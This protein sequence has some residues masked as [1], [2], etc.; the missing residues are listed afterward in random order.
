ML[1]RLLV[2]LAKVLLVF[3][4]V[5]LAVIGYWQY[6]RR[7]VSSSDLLVYLVMLPLGLLLSY[8]LARGILA[9]GRKVLARRRERAMPSQSAHADPVA[10]SASPGQHAEKP[11]LV[12]GSALCSRLG[13]AETWIEKTREYEIHHVLDR[14]LTDAL[15]WAVRSVRVDQLDDD[16]K[17]GDGLPD[18]MQTGV[19]RMAHMLE[20]VKEELSGVLGQAS[21]QATL[22]NRTSA[23]A[24]PHVVLHPAWTGQDSPH[25][26]P[27]PAP[28]AAELPG[29]STLA[30]V[31]FLPGFVTDAEAGALAASSREWALEAG[32]PQ[33]KVAVTRV[34]APDPSVS[35]RR[36]GEVLQQQ[37][38]KPSQLLVVLSAVSWLDETVLAEQLQRNTAWAERLQ[39]SSTVVGEAA[40][41]MVLSTHPL[42]DPVTRVEAPVLAHLSRLSIGERQKP[43]DVK[44]SVE[45]ELLETLSQ[46]LGKAHGILPDQY[47]QLVATG[48][49]WHGR[50]VELGRWLSDCLPHLSLVDD[51]I[52]VGQ[53][54]G[55][56]DPVSDLV[57]LV[58]A[59]ESCRQAGA[60]TLFCSN[61]DPSWRGVA[62]VMPA[63]EVV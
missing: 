37:F 20:R 7:V 40:A 57:A 36:L 13:D 18:D 26:E 12:L 32:W 56:C 54:L 42:T 43:I 41:G 25:A 19:K 22:S 1:R 16:G 8:W 33:E 29:I 5:W 63:T 10:D 4:V 62:A 51:S 48:D 58:L 34:V 30:I 9:A 53:H 2:L 45:A 3:V 15:G 49:L 28:A 6:T 27:E 55:E 50:P 60:P 59:V 61:H 23:A 46:A 21:R 47:R 39:K 52:Q 44:G 31:L 24:D 11:L 17:D 14:P 35:L 38:L